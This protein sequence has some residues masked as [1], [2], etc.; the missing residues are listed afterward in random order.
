MEATL[1]QKKVIDSIERY[2]KVH[3]L[4][5]GDK[6]PPIRSIAEEFG[7]A[8]VTVAQA[9]KS[10]AKNGFV[11]SKT[12]VGT[13][14]IKDIEVRSRRS[15]CRI[16]LISNV[17]YDG[18]LHPYAQIISGIRNS[19]PD[20]E[21]AQLWLSFE[22]GE[23]VLKNTLYYHY[24]MK[25]D[26]EKIVFLLAHCPMWVK[27][28]FYRSNAPC[29]VIGGIEESIPLPN[30]TLSPSA[31]LARIKEAID[32]SNAY[33]AMLLMECGEPLGA[34]R[35]YYD[36]FRDIHKDASILRLN[37]AAEVRRTQLSELLAGPS[38]PRTFVIQGDDAACQII[39]LCSEM[40][41]SIPDDVGII[42]LETF[43]LAEQLRPTITGIYHNYVSIGERVGQ[44]VRRITS[45]QD[46][47]AS[48]GD[49]SPILV[50][51]ESFPNPS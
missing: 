49:L 26:Q 14:I 38:R 4:R 50:Y 25:K 51:R 47:A 11:E 5:A 15:I 37:S 31:V 12:K 22:S 2:V 46:I 48:N 20:A 36:H 17:D 32:K 21:I 16:F 35:Y 8:Q 24:A 30:V 39:R 29:V 34:H 7:F 3:N 42:S 45:G 44:F 33:P 13:T 19:V 27:A 23:E 40:G 41:I 43:P 10:L 9:I 6:L 1:H 28:F 18:S